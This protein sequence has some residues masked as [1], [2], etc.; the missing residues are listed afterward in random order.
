MV[1]I[2]GLLRFGATVDHYPTLWWL[3]PGLILLA[4]SEMVRRG[5]DL[6]AELDTVI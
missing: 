4:V 6:R 1:L 2:G 5:V 3:L